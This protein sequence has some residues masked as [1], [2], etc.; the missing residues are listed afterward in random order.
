M[1][2]MVIPSHKPY[3]I[4]QFLQLFFGEH[5][6]NLKIKMAKALLEEIRNRMPKGWNSEEWIDFI[7]Q[8]MAEDYEDAKALLGYYNTIRW[9]KKKS[10]IPKLLEKKCF[11]FGLTEEGER[12]AKG[13]EVSLF[14]IYRGTCSVVVKVL[15]E[16]HLIKKVNGRYV[17]SDEFERILEGIAE[18]W[19]YWRKERID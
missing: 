19:N 5:P 9:V 8:V 15:K 2:K 14:T 7:L 4:D 13:R 3:T 16:A 11:E 18:F 17:I 12:R 10:E 1:A 6:Q